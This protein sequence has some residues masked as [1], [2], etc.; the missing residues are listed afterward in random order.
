MQERCKQAGVESVSIR[1]SRLGSHIQ[2]GDDSQLVVWPAVLRI[3]HHRL[4]VPSVWEMKSRIAS[5]PSHAGIFMAYKVV[6]QLF[7]R[8]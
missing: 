8:F 5:S 4:C 3:Q 6:V 7:Q 1:I 2:A